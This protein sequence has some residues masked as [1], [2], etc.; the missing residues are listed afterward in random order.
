MSSA[1]SAPEAIVVGGGIIGCTLAY[2]LQKRDIQTLLIDQGQIG[3]ES[4]WATAGIIGPPSGESLPSH[5]AELADRSE[6]RYAGLLAS[7]AEDSI[8]DPG[9]L[10][11]GK[12]LVAFTE[13]EVE[14]AQSR[15]MWQ[16]N[17]GYEARWIEPEEIR[18][19]EPTIPADT[20]LGAYYTPDGGG[21]T[22]HRMTEAIADAFRNAGGEIR[23]YTAA[24]GLIVENDRVTGV[25]TPQG[26]IHAGKVALC[27]GAWTR[28]LGGSISRDLPVIPVKGQMIGVIP[29]ANGSRPRHVTGS[30]SG[31]YVVPRV[32]GTVAVGASLEHRGFDKRVTATAFKHATDLMER[33]SPALLQAQFSSAWAGLRPGTE[34]DTPIMG[35]VPGYEGL[36]IST[37]H[38]RTGIQL[39]P[40]SAVLMADAIAGKSDKLLDSFS[41][42]RF[43]S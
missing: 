15:V 24:T 5:R 6:K 35:P 37:G 21:L 27:A 8:Y 9:F 2:E 18:E 22:G 7:V 16:I 34:D 26:P 30:I 14:L 4:T 19:I 13:A 41:L 25:D 36:W 1:S 3:R 10:R 43:S 39:A 32:D 38:F 31:G 12:V 17:H 40:G 28:F 20:V 23:E 11:I 42:E 33:V 29:E